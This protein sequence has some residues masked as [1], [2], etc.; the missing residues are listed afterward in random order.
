MMSP[1]ESSASVLV[2]GSFSTY[3]SLRDKQAA[4]TVQLFGK[5]SISFY[6]S[7]DE[8]TTLHHLYVCCLLNVSEVPLNK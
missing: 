5:W 3:F 4:A 8:Q 2:P 1:F 7:V 6:L